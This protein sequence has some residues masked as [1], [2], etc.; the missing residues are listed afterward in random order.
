MSAGP[1]EFTAPAPLKFGEPP[2]REGNWSLL[3]VQ[4]NATVHDP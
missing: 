3:S 2:A 1:V 4:E